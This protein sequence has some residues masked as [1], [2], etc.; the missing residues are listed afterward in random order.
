MWDFFAYHLM[1]RSYETPP[2][3]MVGRRFQE[4]LVDTYARNKSNNMDLGPGTW[5]NKEWLWDYSVYHLMQRS[6]K[7]PS[8]DMVGRQF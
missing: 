4:W 6:Y 3:Y 1:Q 8:L 7:T 5:D 2:L